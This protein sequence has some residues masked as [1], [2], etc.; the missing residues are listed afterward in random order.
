MLAVDVIKAKE[1]E[2]EVATLRKKVMEFER[3]GGNV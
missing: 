1:L 3:V 2:G